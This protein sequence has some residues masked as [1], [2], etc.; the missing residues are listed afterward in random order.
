MM[1]GNPM[2]QER[3]EKLHED[4]TRSLHS[5]AK[6]LDWSVVSTEGVEVLTILLRDETEVEP[7]IVMVNYRWANDTGNSGIAHYEFI[8]RER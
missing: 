7:G 1:G 8:D 3:A 6:L 5:N 4:I 2:T